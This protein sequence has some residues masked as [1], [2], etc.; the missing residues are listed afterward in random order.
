MKTRIFLTMIITLIVFISVGQSKKDV[1]DYL[2]ELPKDLKL[3]QNIKQTYLMTTNY[4]DYDMFGNF[5]KETRILAEYSCGLSDEK[6]KWNNVFISHRNQ[7]NTEFIDS[8]KM[9]VMEDFSYVPSDKMLNPESFPIFPSNTTQLQNLVWDMM[10]FEIFAWEYF[11]SLKLNEEYIA[12]SA[13]TEVDLA[14]SGTFEN[15]DIRLLWNGVTKINDEICAVIEYIAMNNPLKIKNDFINIKG[16][17]HYWGNVYVSL[18]DKQIE[19]AIMNEDVIMEIKFP[20]N[21]EIHNS[22]TTRKITLKKLQ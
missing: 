4:V 22:N 17:S 2:L 21:E 15:K 3:N 20:G 6:V 11:D 1:N 13:N 5:Q 10:A 19:Y 7:E 14:G 16:R 9:D 8:K 18:E 12:A